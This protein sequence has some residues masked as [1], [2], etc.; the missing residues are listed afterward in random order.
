MSHSRFLNRA[1]AHPPGGPVRRRAGAST[2]SAGGEPTV[3]STAHQ[4]GGAGAPHAARRGPSEVDLVS[5][6][7]AALGIAVGLFALASAPGTSEPPGL[8][9]G[10]LL[11][12]G[13]VL[14]RVPHT[15]CRLLAA[16]V[17]VV[18]MPALLLIALAVRLSGPGPVLVRQDRRGADG[19]PYP[20]LQFRT[21]AGSPAPEGRTTQ[22]GRLLRAVGLDE[23]PTLFDIARG[24]SLTHLG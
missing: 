7:L 14:A 15:A 19:R 10:A 18:L 17:S 5:A 24:G 23:L 8:L 6:A 12:V 11:L 20:A 22:V 3:R 1:L 21:T 2:R 9:L 13:G 4:E 16:L